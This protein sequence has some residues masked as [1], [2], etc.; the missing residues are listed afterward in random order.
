MAEPEQILRNFQLFINR[1][2]IVQGLASFKISLTL[3]VDSFLKTFFC[4]WCKSELSLFPFRF[5]NNLLVSKKEKSSS[6]SC[7]SCKL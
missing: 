6:I 4:L 5:K 1:S 3:L 2:I 7:R